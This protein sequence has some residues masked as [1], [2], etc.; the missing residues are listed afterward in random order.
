MSMALASS[1]RSDGV[2]RDGMCGLLASLFFLPP[3]IVPSAA[4]D[5]AAGRLLYS[6]R[7]SRDVRH[8]ET[9]A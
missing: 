3:R 4:G 7:T 5:N 2:V 6:G 1:E 9:R 8:D